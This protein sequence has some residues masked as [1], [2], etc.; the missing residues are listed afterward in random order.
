MVE[1]TT[2]NCLHPA[3]RAHLSKS[4]VSFF[5]PTKHM[6]ICVIILITHSGS[7]N[8]QRCLANCSKQGNH[9]GPVILFHF[10]VNGYCKRTTKINYY[11]TT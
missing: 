3:F 4:H 1:L 5:R 8:A 11:S 7:R 9:M 6:H 2:V 10:A